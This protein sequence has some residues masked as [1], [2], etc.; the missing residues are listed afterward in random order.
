MLAYEREFVKNQVIALKETEPI[1]RL[2]KTPRKKIYTETQKEKNFLLPNGVRWSETIGLFSGFYVAVR[3]HNNGFV[4][5]GKNIALASISR[6]LFKWV[7]SK[8]INNYEYARIWLEHYPMGATRPSTHLIAGEIGSIVLS[9]KNTHDTKKI[10]NL[11]PVLNLGLGSNG[12]INYPVKLNFI[13]SSKKSNPFTKKFTIL[14]NEIVTLE[15]D[16]NIPTVFSKNKLSFDASFLDNSRDDNAKNP[17]FPVMESP[18]PP[19]LELV[20]EEFNDK[21]GNG[22]LEGLET[23][24]FIGYVQN[25]GKGIA[26]EP[27]VIFNRKPKNIIY[28]TEKID[29]KDINPGKKKSFNFN[30]KGGLKLKEG[31]SSF[32]FYVSDG[33]G[34]E[35]RPVNVTI[36]TA[37]YLPPEMSLNSFT[38]NDGK[39][40]LADGNDNG[41]V[42]N[43]ESV[44][45]LLSIDNK[46]SGPAYGS[47]L[48]ISMEGLGVIPIQNTV[49]IG[50][51]GPG[52]QVKVP[53]G[54]MVPV[55]FKKNFF[56]F[57]IDI[58]DERNAVRYVEKIKI[59]SQFRYPE[60][61][62]DYLIHDGTSSGSR[63][64]SNGLIEQGEM[65]ELEILPENIGEFEAEDV[66]LSV[67]QNHPGII[68][69]LDGTSNKIHGLPIGYIPEKQFGRKQVIP[70]DVKYT[71]DLGLFEITVNIDLANF[72]GISKKINFEIFEYSADGIALGARGNSQFGNSAPQNIRDWINV[73]NPPKVNNELKNGFAVVI[74][75]RNYGNRDIPQVEYADRDSRIFKTYLTNTIGLSSNKILYKKDA[76][77]S[78][79]NRIFGTKENKQGQLYKQVKNLG[80]N[81]KVF[82]FY[83]GHGAPD[84][85]TNK[86]YIVPS[87]ASMGNIEFEG[88][89]LDQL[90]ISLG[91]LPTKDVT[92][93]IDACFS[94]K[95]E[96]AMLYKNIS[97]ALLKVKSPGVVRGLNVFSSSKND[98]VSS[99]YPKARHG[100]FSYYFFAG[101][102]GNADLNQDGKITNGEMFSYLEEKVPSKVNEL[103]D[104]SRE[105]TPTFVGN[106]DLVLIKSYD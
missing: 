28:E 18:D 87:E 75:N 43:G 89:P 5:L 42:E 13:K 39:I 22:I 88:Y 37:K 36:P 27:S 11:T 40:G 72:D 48:I 51:V 6:F 79:F 24:S 2:T 94:G 15:Y 61:S 34:Y 83:S 17:L 30:I 35:A 91:N 62:F 86:A 104:F 64:N 106:K 12:N 81:A 57:K 55:T 105:Q 76:K 69:R 10:R 63:G 3:L 74:G 65:I 97:P 38:I 14:P 101:M 100:V 8:E 32:E 21:D 26:R 99:W 67:H 7:T 102:Q 31:D 20:I 96:K 78:D 52:A 70:F 85:N 46:G 29:L 77:L 58:K 44:E 45:I 33:R 92:L 71:A 59:E 82:I 23:A 56:S 9:V 95:T 84:L 60:I 41:L 66:T 25:S 103:S 54:F 16:V 68:M 80:K 93:I 49:F 50:S 90:L 47:K 4:S 53:V 19:S 73:D 98:Q 1:K